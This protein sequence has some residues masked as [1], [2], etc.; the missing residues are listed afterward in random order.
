MDMNGKTLTQLTT[1]SVKTSIDMSYYAQGMYMLQIQ[2]EEA[3]ET[4][5][6]VRK[7]FF[8]TAERASKMRGFLSIHFSVMLRTMGV[9]R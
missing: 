6:I 1:E 7:S 4:R 3:V 2:T 9:F 5:R 8:L